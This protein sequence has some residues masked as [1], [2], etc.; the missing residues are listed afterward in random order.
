MIPLAY[1]KSNVF[2]E[3][4]KMSEDEFGY[5]GDGPII[6]PCDAAFLE[7]A[8]SMLRSRAFKDAE[9][10]LFSSLFT[11]HCL[12]SSS[13]AVGDRQQLVVSSF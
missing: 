4:L 10:E 7:Y 2:R 3:L 1:L 6:L 8:L 9:R 5:R 13:L 12:A 11:H